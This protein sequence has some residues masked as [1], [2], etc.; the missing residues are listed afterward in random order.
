MN[1]ES[2]SEITEGVASW[3]FWINSCHVNGVSA[4]GDGSWFW[5]FV[6]KF[7]ATLSLLVEMAFGGGNGRLQVAANDLG[8]KI[9][10]G[11]E[12][13]ALG[14]LEESA[15]AWTEGGC[16][17]PSD[18]VNRGLDSARDIPTEG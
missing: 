6:E 12:E 4:C 5:L 16:V 8:C 2:A 13:I 1:W 15:D 17:E 7:A 3:L 18:K 14:G 10:P 9:G 11:G